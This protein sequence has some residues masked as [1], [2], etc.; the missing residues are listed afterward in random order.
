MAVILQRVAWSKTKAS[1]DGCIL[2]SLSRNWINQWLYLNFMWEGFWLS[3]VTYSQEQPSSI[4]INFI[5]AFISFFEIMWLV[6][7]FAVRATL[8]YA[9]VVLLSSLYLMIKL[10]LWDGK[11]ICCNHSKKSLLPCL[12]GHY[13][14]C[15]NDTKA[16]IASSHLTKFHNGQH[17]RRKKICDPIKYSFNG[18][19]YSRYI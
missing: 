4:N 2:M 9:T 12:W 19:I 8:I 6:H 17:P 7:N 15:E 14:M 3:P 16:L 18:I 1:Q 13:V 10:L 11:A 5:A